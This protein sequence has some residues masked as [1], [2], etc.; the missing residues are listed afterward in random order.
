M[1]TLI[2]RLQQDINDDLGRK[3]ERILNRV[4]IYGGEFTASEI[5]KHST[6]TPACLITCLGWTAASKNS[7]IPNSRSV[8]LAFFIVTKSKDR[9]QRMLQ[10]MSIS[11][12]LCGWLKDWNC[13]DELLNGC[14]SKFDPESIMAENLYGR[15][16]D[17]KGLGLW[18]VR[19][20]IDLS[21]CKQTMPLVQHG[22]D[23]KQFMSSLVAPTYIIESN[24][25]NEVPIELD[26]PLTDIQQSIAINGQSIGEN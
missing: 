22:G 12:R 7:R 26:E 21:Y 13:K 1:S 19:A 11:E 8:K 20:T 18:L 5:G 17:D 15:A 16:T 2:E 24:A 3:G 23:L 6:S 4:E 10:S 25:I 9:T 14:V